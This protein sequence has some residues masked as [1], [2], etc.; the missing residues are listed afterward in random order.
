MARGDHPERT[1]FYGVCLLAGAFLTLWLASSLS[2]LWLSIV[3]GGL[4]V[5]ASGFGFL[6]TFRDLG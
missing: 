5:V 3:I 2:S 6:M 1:P 4:A